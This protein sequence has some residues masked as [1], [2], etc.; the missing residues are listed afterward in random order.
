MKKLLIKLFA[1]VLSVVCCLGFIACNDAD[2]GDGGSGTLT[3]AQ[4]AT[5][6]GSATGVCKDYMLTP[7]LSA[8]SFSV[9]DSDLTEIN[10]P[11]VIYATI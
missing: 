2:N 3:K 10:N 1:L 7:A 4:Y 8:L 11:G 5:A 9:S 6:F